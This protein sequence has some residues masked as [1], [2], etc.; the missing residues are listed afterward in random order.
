VHLLK[1][2]TFNN[3]RNLKHANLKGLGDLNVIIG[4][5][6][7]GKT[8]LLRGIELLRKISLE[9]EPPAVACEKCMTAFVR[10]GTI[11]GVSGTIED[12]EKYLLKH[13]IKLGFVFDINEIAKI[14]SEILER[15]DKIIPLEK[16]RTSTE[17]QNVRL[18]VR[19]EVDKG[20]LILKE[21]R[22]RKLSAEHI[23]VLADQQILER[24]F[25]HILFC[26]DDR[27]QNYKGKSFRDFISSKDFATKEE[28]KFL[29]LLRDIIDPTL[30]DMRHSLNLVKMF[31]EGSFDTTIEEQGSGVKSLICLVADILAEKETKILLIDEPELGLNPS[32]KHAF[33]EFLLDQSKEKQIFLATHDPTFVNPILWN[34]ENV[35]I[36]L[37]SLVNNDFV[38]VNLTESKEDPNTFAGYLPHTTS[39]KQAHIYV[40]GSLDVYIFQIFLNKY[41]KERFDN[42]YQIINK[43]GI[44]HLGG[45]FWSHLL[46]TIPKRPYASI[47]ILDYDKKEQAKRV[48]EAYGTL[49]EGRFRMFN[50]TDDLHNFSHRKKNKKTLP[51][52]PVYCLRN[53]E[54]EDYLNPTPQPKEKGPLIAS[55]MDLVPTE[56]EIIFDAILQFAGIEMLNRRQP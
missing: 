21:Q 16:F 8:S 51:V 5:N 27:L 49:E 23:S 18:H 50:S 24:I 30:A 43:V 15:K 6:N 54:L 10:D 11:L 40:E 47:V 34:K 19:E 29:N 20:Q 12:R 45:D 2:I 7:C 9:R 38:K 42:W 36:Y 28:T 33:L 35:S 26:P 4:P 52:C 14:Y 1:Q 13:K 56:I 53:G 17:L 39:L 55:E 3:F 46:Y 25:S 48:I 37:F 31:R 44:Y 22:N 41:I 32:S